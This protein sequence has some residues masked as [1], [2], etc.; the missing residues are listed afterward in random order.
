M[1]TMKEDRSPTLK[2]LQTA[3][4]RLYTYLCE[5][6]GCYSAAFE[7]YKS[8]KSA[9]DLIHAAELAEDLGNRR[10]VRRL[11]D[12]AKAAADERL[13]F[14]SQLEDVR[15]GMS[16]AMSFKS[17]REEKKIIYGKVESLLNSSSKR[18]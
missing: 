15:G 3:D 14:A 16:A 7:Y 10:Q 12:L 4:P 6:A 2:R 11:C 18:R 13:K 5:K 9:S 1:K 17:A 8:L